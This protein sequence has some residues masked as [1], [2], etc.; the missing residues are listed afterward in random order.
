MKFFCQLVL[1][2]LVLVG[3]NSPIPL[4]NPSEVLA[5]KTPLVCP[6]ADIIE[7]ASSYSDFLEGQVGDVNAMRYS[8]SFSGLQGE[9]SLD[10]EG[11]LKLD[12]FMLFLAQAGV[13]LEADTVTEAPW[14]LVVLHRNGD[15]WA[16]AARQKFVQ[17]IAINRD[18]DSVAIREQ[19]SITVPG[20]SE[21]TISEYS[22]VG[23]FLLNDGQWD[24]NE[25]NPFYFR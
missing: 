9:C 13:G 2:G 24:F 6:K 22:V 20:L 10:A 16:V 25:N 11:N 18:S 8:I 15:Q 21:S 4:L 14:F 19:F 12:L 5:S 17:K 7:Q 1:C 3:C 23:G